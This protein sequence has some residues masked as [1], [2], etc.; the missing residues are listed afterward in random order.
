MSSIC[1]QCGSLLQHDAPRGLC[2]ECLLK[3]G[4]SSRADSAASPDG[5]DPTQPVGFTPPLPSA[6]APKFA[7]L[8]LE[9]LELVG[10]GGMGAV[11]RARQKLLDRTVALKVLPP[12][13]GKDPAFAERFMREAR[14]MAKLTHPNIVWVFDF[15]VVE[16]FY[17]LIMEFVDGVNL[18]VAIHSHQVTCEQALAIV[19][20][21]CDALQYAHEE[22]VVHRDIKPENVLLDKK[23]RVKIADF[24]LA[25]LLGR[26]P[27]D[28]TLTASHQI[29]GTLHYMA[30]EQIERPLQVDHRADI[31]SLG[32]VFYELLT[33]Q[34]PLGRF[35][36]PSERAHLD[37]RLD[38][39]VLKTLQREPDE[40][41]QHASEVRH[42]VETISRSEQCVPPRFHNEEPRPGRPLRLPFS[43]PDLYAGLATAHGMARFDGKHVSIEFEVRD[44]IAGVVRSGVKDAAVSV[45]DILS[46]Q[47]KRGWWKHQVLIQTDHLKV[48]EI[49]NMERGQI[50]LQIARNDL[51]IAERFVAAVDQSIHGTATPAR[52]PR[53]RVFE[54]MRQLTSIPLS[55][56]KPHTSPEAAVRS[57]LRIPA[58]G[59]T[60]V[61]GMNLIAMVI[62]L[63]ATMGIVS[64][65]AEGA[66]VAFCLAVY[67]AIGACQLILAPR[68]LALRSYPL[69]VASAALGAAHVSPFWFLGL[70]FAVWALILLL[71]PE[72]KLAF[73]RVTR[74]DARPLPT[75]ID[76]LL[77]RLGGQGHAR[78]AAPGE[79]DYVSQEVVS[80]ATA[81]ILCGGLLL[82]PPLLVPILGIMA[83][84][85]DDAFFALLLLLLVPPGGVMLYGGLMMRRLRSYPW[86]VAGGIVAICTLLGLPIGVWVLVALADRSVKL[87]FG[88]ATARLRGSAEKKP[89]LAAYGPVSP[90]DMQV[91]R[92][93][94]RG[95]ALGLILVGLMNLAPL[96]LLG[97]ATAVNALAAPGLVRVRPAL[98]FVVGQV[99][100]P[101]E[102]FSWVYAAAAGL[103]IALICVPLAG[104]M[105]LAGSKMRHLELWGLSVLASIVA[106]LPCHVG[107]IIGFPIGIWS[108]M[109]LPSPQTRRAFAS[110]ASHAPA[111]AE[112]RD[113]GAGEGGGGQS[114]FG[115]LAL[116]GLGIAVAVI[117]VSS[118][119]LAR[120]PNLPPARSDLPRSVHLNPEGNE[121]WNT[122][123][124]SAASQ[125]PARCLGVILEGRL[126]EIQESSELISRA[127]PEIHATPALSRDELMD[128]AAI[129]NSGPL[130]A[131]LRQIEP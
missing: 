16:G 57:R 102:A 46:I 11:Y 55:P 26:S 92:D 111:L 72:I 112:D 118:L 39:V 93:R 84:F 70:P 82:L 49:P 36:L 108:L 115:W 106:L 120:R 86:S 85:V 62:A 67:S 69:A 7:H 121:R 50:R 109:V 24:G 123:R 129:L 21:I 12:D 27:V 131:R 95:P 66:G 73:D 74:Q 22:G 81:L 75:L 51:E 37:A 98:G 20:Q 61:G 83:I 4:L 68:I 5:G 78:P 30:P 90:A 59:L 105:L 28:I 13:S 126:V 110:R 41:Y 18:R 31:Y 114:T 97:V 10:Q 32:V 130:P 119:L 101:Q 25:K 56:T 48:G 100:T 14:A 91:V 35:A 89:G 3:Q 64:G 128:W 88:D 127:A 116:A 54:M 99:A 53:H 104:L 38:D 124:A 117:F 33:G 42:D 79:P 103:A 45:Q 77:A 44:E 96:V 63:V 17:Y 43:I 23:G 19:P 113:D 40:R 87:A 107:F 60:V 47:L 125:V 1:P 76:E 122:V 15:G 80:P 6:L 8:Q 52:P 34:L 94:V 2:A 71:K 65:E 9:V 58:I 29:M